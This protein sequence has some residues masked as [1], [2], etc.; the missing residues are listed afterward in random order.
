MKKHKWVAPVS[1]VLL[2]AVTVFVVSQ[3]SKTFT[4]EGF[5]DYVVSVRAWGLAAAVACML[6]YILFEGLGLLTICRALG[7]RQSWRRGVLYSAADIYFSAITPSATGGQPASA[8]FMIGDGIPAAAT[9]VVLM[10]NLVFYT[11]SIFVVMLLGLLLYPGAFGLFSMPAHMLIAVGMFFQAALV[12]GLMLLIFNQKIFLRIV[13]FFLHV[14]QRL[15]LVKTAEKRREKLLE[16]EADYR[17]SAG[18][19]HR[20]KRA[21]AQAFLYNVLQRLSIVLVPVVLYAASGYAP[22]N[23]GRVFAV[24]SWV[25]MGSNS[26]PMPGAVGVAD[27]LFLDGY[28]PL[29]ADPVNL[30]LLSRTVSFYSCVLVCA[31]ILLISFIL[32]K[33]ARKGSK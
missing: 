19:I 8:L 28:G 30:E 26:M 24:Q 18:V 9:T 31:V 32:Q 6:C 10:L 12:A 25:I 20:H 16:M 22:R 13:D 23:L 1:F 4:A 17:A 5:L 7:Y 11:L 33:A 14:A 21:M 29:V 3:Q 2:A 27:Y 15:H